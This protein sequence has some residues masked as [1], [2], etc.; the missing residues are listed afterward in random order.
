MMV[1]MLRARNVSLADPEIIQYFLGE[2][3]FPRI[4]ELLTPD[5]R[6]RVDSM[7]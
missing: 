6:R 1:G 5:E 7:R 4:Y 3:Y 2:P